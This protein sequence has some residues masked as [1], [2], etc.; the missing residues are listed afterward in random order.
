MLKRTVIVSTKALLFESLR[1]AMLSWALCMYYL[2]LVTTYEDGYTFTSIKPR[3][4]LRFRI[5]KYLPT[6]LLKE[7]FF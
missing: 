1:S 4:Q 5:N 3:E 7:I 6:V 2:I